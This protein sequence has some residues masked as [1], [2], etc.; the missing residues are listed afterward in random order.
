VAADSASS[1]NLGVPPGFAQFNATVNATLREYIRFSSFEGQAAR[2][3]V[4]AGTANAGYSPGGSR[5]FSGA[6]ESVDH[7]GLGIRVG[8]VD[9]ADTVW[10]P[11]SHTDVDPATAGVQSY[12]T[13]GELQCF[14][15]GFAGLTREADVQV[16]WGAG[17][18]I[19]SV[20]DATHHVDEDFK[21]GYEASYGFVD[22]FNG[23][24]YI[25]WRDFNYVDIASQYFDNTNGA[26]GFCNHTDPGPGLRSALVSQPVLKPVSVE[27]DPTAGSGTGFGLY[28]NGERYIFRLTGGAAPASGTVW[29]LRTYA[30][31]VRSSSATIQT[32]TPAGYTYAP[33]DRPP[34]IPGL[35]VSFNVAART[36]ATAE[37]DSVLNHVH[38]VRIRTT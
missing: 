14:G 7:P 20:H 34:I 35:K 15:Y 19:A 26:L 30:G 10:A 27:S 31:T 16:T 21:P 24:G 5:W 32:A 33:T 36:L 1:T 11:I 9:G 29:T 12:A 6:N 38:T 37:S 3:G 17:G 22:D 18:Q 4:I 25:D 13:S 23:N 8:H 2:R 28:I